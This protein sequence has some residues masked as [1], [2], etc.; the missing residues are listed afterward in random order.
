MFSVTRGSSATSARG[1]FGVCL[2]SYLGPCLDRGGT[3]TLISVQSRK[4]RLG[5]RHFTPLIRKDGGSHV[6]GGTFVHGPF[7][8]LGEPSTM[9]LW[10]FCF[11][12]VLLVTKFPSLPTETKGKVGWVLCLGPGRRGTP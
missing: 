2:T 1:D 4:L 3:G 9:S 8:V 7:P 6:S 11:L 12:S 10:K 5:R